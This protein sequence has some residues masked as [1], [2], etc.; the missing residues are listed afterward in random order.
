MPGGHPRSTDDW[1]K[2]E[3]CVVRS[4]KRTIEIVVGVQVEVS[5]SAFAELAAN[6]YS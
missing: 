4:P 2:V 1:R 6:V 3:T 5:S